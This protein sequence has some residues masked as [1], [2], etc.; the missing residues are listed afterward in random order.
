MFGGAITE[1]PPC[2]VPSHTKWGHQRE[3]RA[4]GCIVSK[5]DSSEGEQAIS[6]PSPAIHHIRSAVW[7]R[8]KP[9]GLRHGGTRGTRHQASCLFTSHSISPS[10]LGTKSPHATIHFPCAIPLSF[11]SH[12]RLL[13]GSRLL[14]MITFPFLT[15]TAS[16]Q[17]LYLP[18]IPSNRITC[19]IN[20][21]SIPT[22]SQP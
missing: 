7:R 22:T 17:W 20:P 21:I 13:S 19:P 15:T 3:H 16:T 6:F 4:P 2:S 18:G 9:I 5:R 12:E 11:S 10:P 8:G 1:R 14:S